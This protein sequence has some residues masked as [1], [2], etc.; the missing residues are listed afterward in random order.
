MTKEAKQ[1]NP[2]EPNNPQEARK[3][4]FHPFNM[5]TDICT[6]VETLQADSSK[7]PFS[8]YFLNTKN[9]TFAH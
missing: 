4:N 7:S 6:L 3:D 8:N 2:K 5:K 1:L 9:M